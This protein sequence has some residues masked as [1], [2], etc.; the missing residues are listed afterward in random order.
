MLYKFLG[1]VIVFASIAKSGFMEDGRGSATATSATS[2]TSATVPQPP[3][4]GQANL[5]KYETTPFYRVLPVFSQILLGFTGF[6]PILYRIYQ[7]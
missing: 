2:A 5:D 3:A 4:T 7:V 6:L 1:F